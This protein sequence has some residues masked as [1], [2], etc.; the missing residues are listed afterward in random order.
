MLKSKQKSLILLA[1]FLCAVLT[2]HTQCNDAY[3]NSVDCPTAN[4]SLI[5]YNNAINVYNFYEKSLDYVKL[6]SQKLK[7]RQDVLA[8][9]HLLE[10]AV[11]SFALNW[12][13][14][15]RLINGEDLPNVLLPRDGKNI[16]VDQYY[17]QVDAYRFYQREL[18]NGILNTTS[19]FPIYDTRI[20]PLVINAYEN[21]V[22]RDDF[23]GDFVNVALYI[24]VVV[25]PYAMLSDSEKV[26][27][28]EII[29]G[30]VPEK[31]KKKKPQNSPIA[32][33]KRKKVAIVPIKNSTSDYIITTPKNTGS[34]TRPPANAISVYYYNGYGGG[35]L[36]GYLVGRKFRKYLPTDEF[37]WA[38]P[39]WLKS[40]LDD[41]SAVDKYL[42]QRL[43]AYYNGL[44]K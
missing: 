3:G 39:K 19:P 1:T 2:G 36:M 33:N 21:R 37:Y 43:G 26:L 6:S 20:A 10:N 32:K 18:E 16:P 17:L 40:F 29:R 14:R 9:F 35:H 11:D 23:N 8:C 4:D 31:L 42:K 25:K 41:S 27:R 22:S 24:P 30:R 34:F 5:V 13:K 28:E 38:T 7:T 15:E 12:I 44:Y